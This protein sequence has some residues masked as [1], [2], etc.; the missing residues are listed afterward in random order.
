MQ[1]VSPKQFLY[2]L[3]SVLWL[4]KGFHVKE[5]MY[6]VSMEV[7]P[8]NRCLRMLTHICDPN[9]RASPQENITPTEF[10]LYTSIQ[11]KSL[12]DVFLGRKILNLNRIITVPVSEV[13]K[14]TLTT[15]LYGKLNQHT[16]IYRKHKA[17]QLSLIMRCQLK[18][19]G[20]EMCHHS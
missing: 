10:Y 18:F 13:C 14:S 4:S 7:N 6:S 5:I 20:R 1:C 11:F 19:A 2:S 3:V 8:A 9:R 17:P 16:V 12:M 15:W